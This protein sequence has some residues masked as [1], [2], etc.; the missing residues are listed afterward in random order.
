MFHQFI[1][2]EFVEEEC[3]AVIP[4]QCISNYENMQAGQRVK[5]L[6]SNRKEYPM[7]F[8]LSGIRGLNTH[9]CVLESLTSVKIMLLIIFKSGT[10]YVSEKPIIHGDS[11]VNSTSQ[12]DLILQSCIHI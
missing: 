6:W 1:L 7:I 8:F 12:L 9:T 4:L 11:P 2:V 3:T 10:V 5:Y